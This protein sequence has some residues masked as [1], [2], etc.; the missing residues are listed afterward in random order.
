MI[1]VLMIVLPLATNALNPDAGFAVDILIL[2]VFGLLGG[3]V[4]SSTY[5]IAGMLPPKYMGAVMLGNGLSGIIINVLRAICLAA[6]PTSAD[7]P[8]N[9]YY[10][11]LVYFIMAALILVLC[12]GGYILFER[13]EY[14]RY[15]IEKAT[16]EKMKTHRR[17]SHAAEP[18]DEQSQSFLSAGNVNKTKSENLS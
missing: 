1:A 12:S 11:S 6:L 2:V 10:G 5:G 17:I 8:D 4:Q 16:A 9:E 3:F 15:Y 13:L 14:G 18:L 7:H